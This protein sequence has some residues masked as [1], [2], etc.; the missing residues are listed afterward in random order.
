MDQATQQ[1]AARLEETTA[2]SEAL[3]NDA[4]ALV[5]ANVGLAIG[6]TGNDVAA[7]A[8]PVE[9]APVV[10]GAISAFLGRKNDG[11]KLE[12]ALA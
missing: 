10:R 2:A 7:E 1:N 4:V 12:A 8:V 6:G 11:K 5:R 9:T 3:R